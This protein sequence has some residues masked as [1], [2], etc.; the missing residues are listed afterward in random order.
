MEF[1]RKAVL[2]TVMVSALA[3][4]LASGLGPAAADDDLRDINGFTVRVP[5]EIETPDDHVVYSIDR[6]VGEQIYT[7]T[8]GSWV[9]AEP[10]AAS[11]GFGQFVHFRGPTWQST[12]DGSSIQAKVISQSSNGD[13]NIPLLLLQVTRHDRGTGS[14]D[15][16][17]PVDYV[18]RLDTHGGTTRDFPA[19]TPQL[20]GQTRGS[21]YDAVY[22]FSTLNGQAG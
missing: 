3:G 10:R 1:G 20:Q 17:G 15:V 11:I 13:T 18:Q 5:D 8:N 4:L 12:I 19:C 6:A 9:F 2:G 22:A 16:F 14:T 7:C 21:T